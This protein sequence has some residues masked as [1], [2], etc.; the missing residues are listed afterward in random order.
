MKIASL[1][2]KTI[3]ASATD[4]ANSNTSNQ[5][6][7]LGAAREVTGSCHLLEANGLRILL[8][9]GLLQGRDSAKHPIENKFA[10]KPASIDAVILSHAHL[11]HCGMLPRLTHDGFDGPIYCTPGTKQ[12]ISIML[13]DAFHIYSK[14]LEYENIRR[15]RAGKKLLQPAYQERDIKKVLALCVSYDYQ[16]QSDI[17]ND[18]LLTLHDAGHILG[19]SIVELCIR[20]EDKTTTLVF[21]GDLGNNSTSLMNDPHVIEH[22]DIVLMESTYGDRNHRSFDE[23]MDGFLEIL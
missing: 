5:L 16:Q 15:I 21:T 10:F 13:M 17:G 3:T 12:L 6:T 1:S 18:I 11:D 22:A 4:N 20:T 8:D 23:T 2:R 19:S 9:C 14:D 7:F